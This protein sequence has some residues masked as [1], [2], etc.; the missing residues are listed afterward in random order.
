MTW[1]EAQKYCKENHTDLATIDD[2][3]DYDELLETV[4]KDFKGEMWI[5]LYREDANAAWIWS[6]QSKSTFRLWGSG[7]PN[8]Y[9]GKQFCMGTSLAG[10]WNDLE[11]PTKTAFI[12][13]T[14]RADTEGEGTHRR[15]KT[16][17]ENPI[18]W[19]CLPKEPEE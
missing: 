2:Q 13:Y 3:M 11:C 9:G 17:L 4:P 14:D 10:K 16:F 5:G 18:K 1:T 7:Q 19:K 15:C 8:N 12:C 6:D